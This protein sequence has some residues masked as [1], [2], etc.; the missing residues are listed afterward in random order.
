MKKLTLAAVVLHSP[1]L[2]FALVLLFGGLYGL[3]TFAPSPPQMPIATFSDTYGRPIYVIAI[4][5]GAFFLWRT[6]RKIAAVLA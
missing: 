4:A 1:Q 3:A 2:L 6:I 5:T